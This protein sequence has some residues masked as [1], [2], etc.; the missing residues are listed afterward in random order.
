MLLKLFEIYKGTPYLRSIF[1][2]AQRGRA[3]SCLLAWVHLL[4]QSYLPSW[5]GRNVVKRVLK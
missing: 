1:C 4:D 2:F 3:D 5:Y